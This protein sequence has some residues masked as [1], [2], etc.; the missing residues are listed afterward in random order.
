MI[1]PACWRNNLKRGWQ[2]MQHQLCSSACS[3]CVESPTTENQWECSA[4][5]SAGLKRPFCYTPA[6]LSL[7]FSLSTSRDSVSLQLIIILALIVSYRLAIPSRGRTR[8]HMN[9]PTNVTGVV[10]GRRCD[11]ESVAEDPLQL[12]RSSP[13]SPLPSSSI[14]RKDPPPLTAVLW[15][16]YS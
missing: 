2:L 16:F 13:T 5:V 10:Q 1:E 4:L 12:M 8:T 6:A 7:S 9:L 14:C 11:C 3:Q 15:S